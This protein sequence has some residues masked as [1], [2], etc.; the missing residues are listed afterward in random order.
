MELIIDQYTMGLHLS[1]AVYSAKDSYQDAD[2]DLL[3]CYDGSNA[4]VL[5]ILEPSASKSASNGVTP[6]RRGILLPP[7]GTHVQSLVIT[8]NG[9]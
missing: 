7:E 3:D 4:K 5:A 1:P 2:L 8:A 9:T 6:L